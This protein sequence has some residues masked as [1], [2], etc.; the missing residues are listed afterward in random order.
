MHDHHHDLIGAHR[1]IKLVRELTYTSRNFAMDGAK[2][3]NI[4][5]CDS[6]GSIV[7]AKAHNS[8]GKF[9]VVHIKLVMANLLSNII[10]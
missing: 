10:A 4:M 9:A 1:G 8:D 5:V 6:E 3:V 2:A 7:E